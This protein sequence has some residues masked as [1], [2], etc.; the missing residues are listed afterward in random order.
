MSTASAADAFRA[1]FER[2]QGDLPGPADARR[3]A[4]DAF[5]E[6]GLPTRR[7][8]DWRFTS[9][10]SFA[11][12]AFAAATPGADGGALIEQAAGAVGEA[13]RLSLVNGHVSGLPAGLPSGVAVG[14]LA[15]VLRD[16]PERVAGR[17]G[18]IADEKQ[19][20]FTALNRALFADGALVEI[21]EGVSLERPIH[22]VHAL[23]APDGPLAAHP[24]HLIDVGAG[25]RAVIVE[26]TVGATGEVGFANPVTEI[27]VGRDARVDH[28]VLQEQGRDG[29]Q[30]AATAVHQQGGSH[31]TSHSIALGGRLARLDLRVEL[32]GEAAYARLLGLYLARDTQLLDHH[33]TIDHAMPH[34]SS[35]ELYKGILDERAVAVFHGRIHVRPHAQKITAMQQSRN[36]LLSDRARVH[37]KPQLEIRADDVRCSHG[38]SIGQLDQSQ[39]F[40]LRARGI[41]TDQA[42]ALLMLAFASEVLERLPV[43]ALRQR[44]E[45]VALD[46][47]PRTDA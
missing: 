18:S 35:D 20:A 26:H 31:F 25:S 29:Y 10:S 47:L 3:A 27:L 40:Y 15:E 36:L 34:T 42:R 12:Q 39:L 5:V 46:W 22:L 16:E 4:L 38:A 13:W 6:Q 41:G 1:H 23:R 28:V 32:A 2:L 14:S 8:E 30:L 37:T 24:R 44:L 17:L 45:R 11:G 33:T 43:P 7:D 19:R 21:A 9:L